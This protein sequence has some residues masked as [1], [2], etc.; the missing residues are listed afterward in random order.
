MMLF[1]K[2]EMGTQLTLE[3]KCK[4][5]VALRGTKALNTKGWEKQTALT[6]AG[7]HKALG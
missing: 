5:G 4:A 2:V 7:G 3:C 6:F 1:L